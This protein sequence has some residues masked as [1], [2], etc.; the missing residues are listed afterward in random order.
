MELL[1][2]LENGKCFSLDEVYSL[3]KESFCSCNRAKV[4]VPV[5]QN[6]TILPEFTTSTCLCSQSAV[7]IVLLHL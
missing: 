3:N 7:N 4:P 6:G 1:V 2:G 5:L